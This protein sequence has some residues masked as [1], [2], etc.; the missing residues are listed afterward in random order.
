MAP[1]VNIQTAEGY[2]VSV[3]LSVLYRDRRSVKVMTR[4]SGP[5]QLYEDALVIPRARAGSCASALGE[6][7][8]EEFYDGDKRADRRRG[9]A[10]R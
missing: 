1:G 4:P 9:A 5:G 6:L 3:D 8:A 7:D 2:T 10:R